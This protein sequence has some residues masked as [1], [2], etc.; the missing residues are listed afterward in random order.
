MINTE[1]LFAQGRQ[2]G[3]SPFRNFDGNTNLLCHNR[4]TVARSFDSR[5]NQNAHFLLL[6]GV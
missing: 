1:L 3:L 6:V 4:C 2:C 5:N